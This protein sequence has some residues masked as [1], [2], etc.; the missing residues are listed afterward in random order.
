MIK[1]GLNAAP[2]ASKN[3]FNVIESQLFQKVNS[4]A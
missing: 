2:I 3:T 4:E 1:L